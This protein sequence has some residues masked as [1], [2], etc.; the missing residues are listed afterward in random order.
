VAEH[1]FRIEDGPPSGPH[2]ELLVFEM[3]GDQVVRV[4]I[5]ENYAVPV[6]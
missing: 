4:K 5:G 3:K 2:G 1:K 6:K